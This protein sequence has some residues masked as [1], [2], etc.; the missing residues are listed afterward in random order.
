MLCLRPKKEEGGKEGLP[1]H[2]IISKINNLNAL[3]VV[4]VLQNSFLPYA[5]AKLVI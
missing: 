2:E 1:K 5:I 4:A 3:S